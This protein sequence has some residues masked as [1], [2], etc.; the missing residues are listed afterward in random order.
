MSQKLEHLKVFSDEN[1]YENLKIDN[2][3]ELAYK[4]HD[5]NVIDDEERNQLGA[6]GAF[7]VFLSFLFIKKSVVFIIL[8]I[9]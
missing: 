2:I 6:S 8:T 4:E 7:K 3:D 9:L 5:K 1:D